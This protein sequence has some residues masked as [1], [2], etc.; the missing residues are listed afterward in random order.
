[1]DKKPIIGLL[2]LYDPKKDSYWMLPQYVEALEACGA[3]ALILP[4]RMSPADRQR[5]LTLCDGLLFPGGQ[6]VEP[7]LYGMERSPYCAPSAKR[8]DDLEFPLCREAFAADVPMLGICRGLQ[9]FNTALGGTLYQHLPAEQPQVMNHDMTAP[10]DRVFHMAT[11]S[12]PLSALLGKT[13][14]GVNSYH[15]Q[16]I[17]DVAPPLRVMAE[18]PD[19]V[20]EA[21]YAPE[22]TF[23]WGIQWHPEYFWKTEQGEIFLAFVDAARKKM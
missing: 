16:S 18:A 1:M 11:L 23:L 15:H 6:D 9:L 22:K 21:V 10:Y 3:M 5:T 13:E 4:P 12:G 20:V 14:L 8:R 7:T 17:K 2:P 19:G